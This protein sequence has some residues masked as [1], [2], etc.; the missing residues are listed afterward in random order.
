M[1]VS[2]ILTLE[3]FP[4]IPS[5]SLA[6]TVKFRITSLKEILLVAFD[7]KPRIVGLVL[8]T[9]NVYEVVFSFSPSSTAFAVNM[10]SPTEQ[11]SAEALDNR[12]HTSPPI[13][14]MSSI[15]LFPSITFDTLLAAIVSLSSA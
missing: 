11:P 10:Q 3:R 1:L 2:F 8:S 5:L 15:V 9:V 6:V 12:D 14:V 13:Y 7:S 4:V